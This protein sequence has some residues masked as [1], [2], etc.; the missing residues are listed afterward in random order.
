MTNF[1]AQTYHVI[2]LMSGT[3]LDGLDIAFCR[4]VVENGVWNYEILQAETKPYPQMWKERILSLEKADAREFE[5]AHVDYGQYLGQHVS[6]FIVKY[7]IKADFVSSHGHTIFHQPEKRLTVQIGSGSAIAAACKL[8][9]VCDFRSLDVALGGQGAP[10]VPIGDQ[11]LFAPYDYCL[12]L[13]GFANISYLHEGKRIAYDICPLNIMMNPIAEKSGK[14]YDDKGAMARS[15]MVSTYILAEFNQLAFYRQQPHTPKSL[16]KEWVIDNMDPILDQYEIAENDLLA[17]LCE[18]FAIHIAKVA[19]TNKAAKMLVT[20]GGAYNDHLIERIKEHSAAQI[21]LPDKNTIEFKEALI[22]AF[23]G[24][25]RMRNE[26]N[27]LKSVTGARRDSSG[28]S[29]YYGA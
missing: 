24:V 9:V 10:L 13:G 15:G 3:S 18:H 8:P 21:V 25:L 26:I 2:G 12:N 23:L 4:F 28:G 22:F 7:G 19:G 1:G 29:I 20:G 27:C 16:G 17:T 6:D 14:P 5:Q 11:L